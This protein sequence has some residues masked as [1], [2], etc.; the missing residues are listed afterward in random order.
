MRPIFKIL[1]FLILIIG[2]STIS[3]AS[4]N[5]YVRDGGGTPTQC[6]GKV[7]AVYPGSG[8]AQPCAFNHP[9]YVLGYGCTNFGTTCAFAKIMAS[10]DTL[11]IDGDSDIT[12]GAQAQYMVGFDSS[13]GGTTPSCSSGASYDCTLGNV[14]AGPSALNKTSIIGTG[15]HKPQ[16]WGNQRVWQVLN[17][18]NNHILLQWLEITDHQ[19]CAY[20]Q[21]G[22]GGCNYNGPYPYGAWAEDGLFL[23]GDDVNLVDVYEHGVGRFGM[24]SDNFVNLNMTRTYFIGNGYAGVSTGTAATITGTVTWNQ[25]I[26]TWNGC[27]EQYPMTNSGVSNA[28]NYSGCFGQNSNGYGDGVAFGNTGSG[29]PGNWTIIGPGSMSFNTQDGLDTLHGVGNGTMQIDKM[30][31]EG[32][33]GNQVKLNSLNAYITNSVVFGD[34]GWWFGAPQTLVGAM[35]NGDAC[36]AGGNAILF[37]VTNGSISDI[38]NTTIISNGNVAL[39][40]EDV[41][42]TGCNSA[43]KINVNSN[44]IFGG[45]WWGDDTSFNP[46]G[47]NRMASYF[48]NS[49]NNFDG[50]G[51]CGTLTW[52]ED[53]NIV[54]GFKN[55]NAGCVGP[56][57]KCGTAPG[58]TSTI[59]MGTSGGGASTY[60]QGQLGI[61]LV[62]LSVTSAAISAGLSGLFYWNNPNDYYNNVRPSPQ[63]LGAEEYLSCAAPVYGCLLNSD[64]CGGSCTNNVCGSGS[65]TSIGGVCA[66]GGDCCSGICCSSVC[67]TSCGSGQNVI[68]QLTGMC[69]TVGK[70]GF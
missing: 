48:F 55:S 17:A 49:G 23:G 59:P 30:L 25:P 15:T 40:S 66:V 16:L 4:I 36:R 20:N 50:G 32:N 33:G 35:L 8:T 70:V 42:S 38:Y 21:A 24:Y 67:S 27:I 39:V 31:F 47:S 41:N 6:T 57:D 1:I 22:A 3:H 5:Y 60:Y 61:T 54:T 12:P 29:N 28:S 10:G 43:T 9:R 68:D 58:F 65:C 11:F 69:A 13:G 34:C 46:S 64:C 37:N 7:N 19:A 63:A 18:D 62:P 52:N 56:N 53:Y 2:F 45:F 26:V 44:I 14:P 51:T